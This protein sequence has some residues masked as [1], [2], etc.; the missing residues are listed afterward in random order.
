VR[1]PKLDDDLAL[2]AK[3]SDPIFDN[4]PR[5]NPGRKSGENARHTGDDRP[6]QNV[7][8]PLLLDGS[9]FGI[10]FTQPYFCFART[11]WLEFGAPEL[12]P[13]PELLGPYPREFFSPDLDF[14]GHLRTLR[15][16]LTEKISIE[17]IV[18][19]S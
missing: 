4:R 9:R 13:K 6:S 15:R 5:C 8:K 19:L 7:A 1:H 17:H 3:S 12:K 18:I 14:I 16:Q 10:F 11:F 2:K